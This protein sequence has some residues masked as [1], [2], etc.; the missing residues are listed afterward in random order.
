MFGSSQCELGELNQNLILNTAGK[1]K[2]RYGQKFVD[3]LNDQ[4]ELNIPNELLK[5]INSLEQEIKLLKEK[6]K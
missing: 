1:V 5:K 2:I 4:G 6:L 3:L